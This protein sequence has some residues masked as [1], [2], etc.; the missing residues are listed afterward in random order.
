DRAPGEEG[1]AL[2][3]LRSAGACLVQDAAPVT[4]ERAGDFRPGVREEGKHVDFGVPEVMA[5]VA[6]S[7]ETFGRDAGA[8]VPPGGLE[9]AEEIVPQA[10]LQPLVTVELDVRRAPEIVQDPF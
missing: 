9:E 1:T 7:G 4:Q 8:P 2:A 5:F 6:L 3:H 10:L